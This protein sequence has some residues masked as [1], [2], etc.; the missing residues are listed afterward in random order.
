VSGQPLA[1]RVLVAAC[2]P[3]MCSGCAG[4]NV[5]PPSRPA[6]ISPDPMTDAREPLLSDASTPSAPNPP[7]QVRSAEAVVRAQI[8]PRA[9]ACYQEV[10]GR[11]T[12]VYGRVVIQ[13]H[14]APTGEVDRA[15]AMRTQGVLPPSFTSC[16]ENAVRAARFEAPG[17][18]GALLSIPFNFER[19]H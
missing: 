8:H 2:V 16:L 15:D 5:A 1:S 3:A 12:S 10:L 14:V 19:G 6:V 13:L 4:A 7:L 11:D 17:G 18:D 9:K